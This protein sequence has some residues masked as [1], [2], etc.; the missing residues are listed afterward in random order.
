MIQTQGSNFRFWEESGRSLDVAVLPHQP[1][2][3]WLNSDIEAEEP[4]ALVDFSPHL[5]WEENTVLPRRYPLAVAA[6]SHLPML[7][8]FRMEER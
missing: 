2:S 6:V 4:S 7:G 1:G 3:M 8:N 5:K